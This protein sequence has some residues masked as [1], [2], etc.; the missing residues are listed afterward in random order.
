MQDGLG[1]TF[2]SSFAIQEQIFIKDIKPVAQKNIQIVKACCIICCEQ[3]SHLKPTLVCEFNLGSLHIIMN[4][5]I[6]L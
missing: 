2:C 6:T 3:V 4:I 5:V 1:Q